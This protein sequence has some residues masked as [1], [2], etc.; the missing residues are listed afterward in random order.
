ME[1]LKLILAFIML[2]S[3]CKGIY[4]QD[5]I[6]E[7][8]H[9][10][11]I[12]GKFSPANV[13]GG[14]YKPHR[15][16]VIGA[17]EYA[18]FKV[19]I[20][21]VQ[22]ANETVASGEWPIGQAPTYMN[23]LLALN[24]NT[25]GNYWER[26]NPVTEQLSAWYQEVSRGQMHVTGRAYNIIL[27]Y[28]AN[29][30]RNYTNPYDPNLNMR[31][32]NNEILTKLTAAGIRWEE[33]DQWSGSDGNFY[34]LPDNYID[35]IIKVH[36]TKTV[37]GLF[38]E[39]APGYALLGYNPYSSYYF[40]MGN[41]KR[42]SDGF[43]SPYGSGVTL[44]GTAGGPVGKGFAFNGAKH[45][46]GHYWYGAGHTG[47]GVGIMGA[48]INLG[49]WESMKLGYLSSTI[50][51]FNNTYSLYDISSRTSNGEVLQVP[52]YG[53]S[54]Y[55][56]ITNNRKV[57]YFDRMMIGDTAREIWDRELSPD[58]DYGKGIYIFHHAHDMTYSGANDLECA[59]GLWN[60]TMTGQ[61]T[62]DWSSTQI[63]D[64]YERTSLP[65][66]VLN[67]VGIESWE[68]N[69]K[70][71]RTLSYGVYFGRGRR[72]QY[73]G[74]EAIDRFWTNDDNLWTKREYA[75]DRYDA[76]NIGYNEVFSPYSNPNTKSWYNNETSIFIYYNA[77]APLTNE[78][79]LTIYKV[80]ENHTL[81][82]ILEATPPSKPMGLKEIQCYYDGTYNRPQIT[83]T[84][85]MEPDME[86]TNGEIPVKRY[87][88][89]KVKT[90]DMNTVPSE[91][92]YQLLATVD[93]P[94]NVTPTYIDYS[95]ISACYLPDEAPC[96]PWCWIVYPMR[97]RVQ[98][99][100][101]GNGII[102]DKVSVKSDFAQV[103]GMRLENQGQQGGQEN[104]NPGIHKPDK[105]IPNTFD[106]KQNYPNPFNPVT[107]I[108]FDLPKD[109]FVTIKIY[110]LLGREIKTLVS[111]FKNA[112]SHIVSFNGSELA[113]GI[114][115]YRI[116]A[117]SFIS[118][119][120][121]VLIK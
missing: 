6:K 11:F 21:F 68:F 29:Y 48:A 47:Q 35:M 36:R 93:I 3:L 110:D 18:T 38:L 119:K 55:F 66:S 34:F 102:D 105:L 24:K 53:S 87:K 43:Y 25:N 60:W 107:N 27:D 99:V 22:F 63:I 116:Q 98:A 82:S 86:R 103:L 77:F 30:Y 78:S 52:I 65:Y 46:I 32:M 57:S 76:W 83:W 19:L 79:Q 40:D 61:S 118:V 54:E 114:Y 7:C 8:P 71:G 37:D 72:H 121:M 104:D 100:D 75:G 4:S 96:P 92:G 17:P 106:L 69:N 13:I 58:V 14:L 5:Y 120:R 41:G 9:S 20:V 39:N 1:N 88:I 80:D 97:Y 59:D 90:N 44:V 70:D 74:G 50:V 15:T 45:E 117:G 85:N 112:G 23:N 95:E 26:Y 33:Y 109:I 73:V 101:N 10:Q 28:D 108:K 56:L 12:E 84:H 51:N 113:S 49:T 67:D 64:V 2:M 111:E 81:N 16:D 89:W 31:N 91:T 115:F 94:S 42:I 62:P